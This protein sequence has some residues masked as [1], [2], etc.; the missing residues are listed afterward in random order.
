MQQTE[1]KNIKI[2]QSMK[3]ISSYELFP[4]INNKYLCLVLHCHYYQNRLEC[5]GCATSNLLT[6]I[7]RK[8]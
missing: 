2:F 6:H 7:R 1:K 3:E 4:T 5:S 8:V